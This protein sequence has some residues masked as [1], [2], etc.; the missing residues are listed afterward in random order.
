MTLKV[1]FGAKFSR[2][3]GAVMVAGYIAF[4]VLEFVVVQRVVD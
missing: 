4:I 3:I 1:W 2:C